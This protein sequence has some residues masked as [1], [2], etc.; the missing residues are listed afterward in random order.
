MRR[1]AADA[2]EVEPVD[3]E[4]IV[5]EPAPASPRPVRAR[6]PKGWLIAVVV[7]AVLWAG[8]AFATR[9]QS[10]HAALPAPAPPALATPS[11]PLP[12]SFI[13]S[14]AGVGTGRFAAVV[15]GTLYTFDATAHSSA[16]VDLGVDAEPVTI[17]DQSGRELLVRTKNDNVIV[18]TT[19]LGT[20]SIPIDRS[21]ISSH[22]GNWWFVGSSRDVSRYDVA[23]AV[24]IP[25]GIDVLGAFSNGFI[26]AANHGFAFWAQGDDTTRPIAPN[27]TKLVTTN[28]DAALFAVNC[29]GDESCDEIVQADGTTQAFSA[30]NFVGPTALSPDEAEVVTG[31][32]VYATM[33]GNV[34][35][36]FTLPVTKAPLPYA[37]TNDGTLLIAL[38]GAV[39]V[40][41]PGDRDVN[42]IIGLNGLTQIAALP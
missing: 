14:F 11:G 15:N 35:A 41:H 28:E 20:M 16:P 12:A 1:R 9:H 25:P 2:L 38:D 8:I 17:E 42:Q 21:A 5:V 24:R 13:D 30:P 22:D 10:R 3:L 40:L 37:W 26:V 4:P 29:A 23:A 7:V 36:A 6:R 33:T 32:A 39:G 19:G 27:A 31:N 34:A 18:D